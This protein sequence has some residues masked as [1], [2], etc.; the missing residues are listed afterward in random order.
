MLSTCSALLMS[1]PSHRT[2]SPPS[3]LVY[4]NSLCLLIPAQ[5][6]PLWNHLKPPAHPTVLSCE[7]RTYNMVFSFDIIMKCLVVPHIIILLEC[8]YILWLFNMF[9]LLT[10][11]YT[12]WRQEP[13]LKTL[14]SSV[15]SHKYLMTVWWLVAFRGIW[16]SSPST[17]N[18]QPIS[19]IFCGKWGYVF[20]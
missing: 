5:I 3:S 18:L 7:L 2:S 9:F 17:S 15:T 14:L 1:I 20:S 4:P 10:I 6:L 12:S 16:K 19:D 8:F 11:S 13:C